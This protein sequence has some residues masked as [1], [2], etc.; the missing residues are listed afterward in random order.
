MN[1]ISGIGTSSFFAVSSYSAGIAT[2]DNLGNDITATYLSGVPEGYAT[3]AWVDEQGYLTDSALD[4]YVTIEENT[5]LSA[6]VNKKLYSSAYNPKAGIDIKIDESVDISDLPWKLI[7]QIGIN[8]NGTVA[9]S[10]DMSFVAGSG[11][12]ASG[13]G[14]F[15]NGINTSAK[16]KGTHAEGYETV[17]SANAYAHAEGMQTS[18]MGYGSHAEGNNTFVSGDYSHAEGYCTIASGNYQ[19]VQGQFNDP[20]TTDLFQIGNGTSNNA[21]SNAFIV[22][23]NGLASASNLGTSGYPD[24]DNTLSTM[25]QAIAGAGSFKVVSLTTAAPIVPDVNDP[26]TKVI[27]LTKDTTAIVTDPY[28]EWI[29]LSGTGGATSSWE[30]IGD[31]SMNLDGYIQCPAAY[32]AGHIV[33]FT[34]N[35]A[36]SDTGYTVSDLQNVQA[37]WN[38]T[39]TTADSYIQNKPDVL[40]PQVGTEASATPKYIMVVTAMPAAAQIDPNTIYLV[41]GTYI[42]N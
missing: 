42:G 35:S 25:E 19:H 27:Y 18:A 9:N 20:N 12:Y 6:E 23:S 28:K 30:C 8:T 1:V 7:Q 32:T 13:V 29:W 10:A 34:A 16:G 36:I 38:E 11:T 15:A 33:Q 5:E 21:R 17:A 3:T 22:Q 14:A 26:S 41:Q 40:I 39:V 37:D 31:T 2:Q 24:I 4:D